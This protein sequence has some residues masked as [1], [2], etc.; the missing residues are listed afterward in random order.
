MIGR[1]DWLKAAALGALGAACRSSRDGVPPAAT[2]SAGSARADRGS[3]DDDRALAPFDQLVT[4]FIAEQRI[5]GASLAV[6][7]RGRLVYARG[8]GVA[9]REAGTPVVPAS[10]F[11]IASITKPVTSAAVMQLV[12]AG[13]LALDARV[14]DVLAPLDAPA[15][16]RWRDITIAHLLRHRAGFDRAMTADSFDPMFHPDRVAAALG[17]AAGAP[18]GHREL[19]RYMLAQ[20]LAYAPGTR[21]VYANFDYCLLG[22]VIERVTGG[23]YDADVRARVLEP[24]GIG[25]MQLGR[26]LLADRAAGEVRYYGA[27]PAYGA[28]PLELMDSHGGWI[29]TA[30]DLLRFARALDGTALLRAS[31]LAATFARPDGDPGDVWYGLG[32]QVRDVGDHQINTWH[33]GSLDGSSTLLVRRWDGLAWAILFDTRDTPSGDEPASLIDPLLHRAADAVARWPDRDLFT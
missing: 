21:F 18:V 28:W 17:L 9:D 25:D 16:A 23:T 12:D 30:S 29:A 6:A 7:R 22:R 13:R 15:D 10:R 11:R 24:L 19:V 2:G 27:A 8:F 20:P 14:L 31:S 32:W 4:S 1:R 3:A 5:P 26:S 33:T